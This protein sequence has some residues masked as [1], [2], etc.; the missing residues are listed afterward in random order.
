MTSAEQKK[1]KVYL[2]ITLFLA[3]VAMS[4]IVFAFPHVSEDTSS[5]HYGP[6]EEISLEGEAASHAEPTSAESEG[7]ARKVGNFLVKGKEAVVDAVAGDSSNEDNI[8]LEMSSNDVLSPEVENAS[9]VQGPKEEIIYTDYPNFVSGDDLAEQHIDI[10]AVALVRCQFKSQYFNES[11]QPWAEIGFS[12]GSGVMV[13]ADG[14]VLTAAHVVHDRSAV[15]GAAGRIWT[16]D[17]CHIARTTNVARKIQSKAPNSIGN[18]PWFEEVEII[19]EPGADKY[20]HSAGVDVAL[21][22]VKN[23]TQ[24]YPYVTLVPTMVA[25]EEGIYNVVAI[26]YPGKDTS[27]Q[28]LERFDAAFFG[29]D[30]LEGSGCVSKQFTKPCGWRYVTARYLPDIKQYLNVLTEWGTES[31]AVRPGYSGGPVF[32]NGNV[33]GIAT[34]AQSSSEYDDGPLS[35]QDV[36][37][38]LTSYDIVETLKAEGISL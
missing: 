8:A 5:V 11:S 6:T 9:Q 4:T 14:L 23:P 21:L 15:E 18:E 1:S 22:R 30:S 38:V 36:V 33:I 24:T 19:Y 12:F 10:G 16:F 26:G 13:S 32:Y 2:T 20:K 7:F 27:M 29:V 34:H 35:E 37:Y 25:L 3:F 31:M 28:L 17:T